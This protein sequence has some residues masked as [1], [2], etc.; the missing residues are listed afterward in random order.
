MT[1]GGGMFSSGLV[2]WRSAGGVAS[3]VGGSAGGT[4]SFVGGVAGGVV[5]LDGGVVLFLDGVGFTG[6]TV[7]FV[8]G[9]LGIGFVLLG[10]GIIGWVVFVTG[11]GFGKVLLS[12]F[13]KPVRFLSMIGAVLGG[14]GLLATL[15]KNYKLRLLKLD[16]YFLGILS[17]IVF[18]IKVS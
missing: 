14:V 13:Y 1:S 12:A 10:Y 15:I 3:I 11:F 2:Y 5:S 6:G 9:V 8:V 18:N 7:V 4:V 16:L 17:D